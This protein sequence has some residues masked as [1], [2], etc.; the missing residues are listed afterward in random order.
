MA[1]ISEEKKVER[2]NLLTTVFTPTSPIIDKELF[3]GRQHQVNRIISTIITP[4][5][6]AILYGE[7]GIGKS[8]LANVIPAFLTEKTQ[9]KTSGGQVT[10]VTCTKDDTFKTLWER[11]LKQISFTQEII[12]DQIG[13]LQEKRQHLSLFL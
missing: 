10:R 8:S 12:N 5:E 4:G 13:F 11:T 3:I 1:D 9:F 7:R 6:H 2:F